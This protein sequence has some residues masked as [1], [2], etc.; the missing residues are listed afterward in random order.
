[1][2]ALYTAFYGAVGAG[3]LWMSAGQ[4]I[5]FFALIGGAFLAMALWVAVK[6]CRKKWDPTL[7]LAY[8]LL[9]LCYLYRGITE[10]TGF[11]VGAAVCWVL[12]GALYGAEAIRKF[13]RPPED[14]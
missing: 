13:R 14:G 9:A 1:M 12:I 7:N 6:G 5:G 10:P 3:L 2:R 8:M 4:G 11:H